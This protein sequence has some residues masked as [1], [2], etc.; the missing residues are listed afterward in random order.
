MA[1]TN[2]EPQN[3]S[4]QKIPYDVGLGQR[5]NL[6]GDKARTEKFS[7]KRRQDI[8]NDYIEQELDTSIKRLE[9]TLDSDVLAFVGDILGGVDDVFREV[10]EQKVSRRPRKHKLTIIITTL[11]G[12]IEIVQRMVDTVRHHY[13]IV[14]FI[15]P[16]YAY[17]A[18]TVFVMSG[19]KIHMDYYSRLGPIDPQ[20]ETK[21]GRSVPA[22]GYLKQWERLL[23]KAQSGDISLPEVQLMIQRFD[24]AELYQYE[25]ARELSISL[26][27]DWL[28]KY[29]FKNWIVTKSR[30]LTVTPAMRKRRAKEIAEELNNTDRWHTHGYGISMQVLQRKLKLIIDDFEKNKTLCTQICDYQSLLDDY[31]IKMRQRGIIHVEGIY[32]VM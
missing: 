26:L 32:Y 3:K 25:Q 21:D 24:Q 10:I 27:E 4:I 17:S 28:A 23:E 13:K 11:G 18:G 30:K 2:L 31:M 6:Q 7:P 14:E 12:Y 29:K 16:N 19:D 8:A 1:T 22:L 20:V 15:V 5:D 9:T